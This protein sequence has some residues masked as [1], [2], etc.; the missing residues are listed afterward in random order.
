[1]I[2]T[3][4]GAVQVTRWLATD[5]EQ[6]WTFTPNPNAE[7]LV[8]ALTPLSPVTT[9]PMPYQLQVDTK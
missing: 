3:V 1:M 2:E 6:S 4:N 9:I 7:S 8:L 5:T